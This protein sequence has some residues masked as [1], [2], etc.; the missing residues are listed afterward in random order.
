MQADITIHQVNHVNVYVECSDA[1][2][3]ELRDY[4]TFMVPGYQFM[5]AFK[6]RIWDGKIRIFN[7]RDHSLYKGLIPKLEKFATNR[8]YHLVYCL[9]YTSPSPRD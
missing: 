5:P 2:A 4:F 3:S 1:I 8:N 9:L 6:A 7:I